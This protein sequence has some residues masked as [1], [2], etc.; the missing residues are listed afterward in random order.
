MPVHAEGHSG[1]D[2]ARWHTQTT[3]SRHTHQTAKHLLLGSANRNQMICLDV[4]FLSKQIASFK[5]CLEMSVVQLF[6]RSVVV[7]C[8]LPGRLTFVS[9]HSNGDDKESTQHIEQRYGG[10]QCPFILALGAL[11]ALLDPCAKRKKTTWL[12]RAKRSTRDMWVEFSVS[13]G[14]SASRSPTSEQTALES[15]LKT[16]LRARW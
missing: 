6:L 5:W 8:S 1:D 13:E 4:R 9:K 3:H 2:G 11:G 10:L 16:S 12:K 7:W 15:T 14:L